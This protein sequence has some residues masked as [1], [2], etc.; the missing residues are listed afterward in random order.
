MF[1]YKPFIANRRNRNLKDLIGQTAI[2]NNKVVRKKQR[3]KGKCCSCLTKTSNLCCRQITSTSS[4]TSHQTKK[5]YTI[6]H[7][8][9]CK[10]NFVIY[11]MQCRKCS[12]QYVGKTETPFNHRLNN[13]R[14]NAY[15]PKQDTIPACR[16]FTE[17]NHDFNRDAK[18]TLIEQI[19]DTTKTHSQRQ[20]IIIERENFWITELKTLAP[21][22]LNQDHLTKL[23][24][25][26]V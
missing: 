20:K 24:A 12:I 4:F 21:Y 26:I 13:H 17:N 7:N 10:S 1:K 15:R 9:T 19:H 2:K 11:L 6:Y 16:H 25:L 23:E 14:N 18:F 3:T 22:G 8:T 5:S